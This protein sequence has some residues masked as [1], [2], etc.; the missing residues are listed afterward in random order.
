MAFCYKAP[1]FDNGRCPEDHA[2]IRI[3]HAGLEA[4]D[5]GFQKERFVGSL[6]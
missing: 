4:Q 5:K 1:T 2:S 3:L 6:C